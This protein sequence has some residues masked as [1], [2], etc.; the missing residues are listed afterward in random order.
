[1]AANFQHDPQNR[2]QSISQELP[3]DA[4][5]KAIPHLARSE[6][7]RVE[8]ENSKTCFHYRLEVFSYTVKFEKL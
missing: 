2:K 7:S 8:R 4:N 5:S 6:T 3:T 1:M